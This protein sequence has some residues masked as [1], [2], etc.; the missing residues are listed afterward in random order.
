GPGGMDKG[1]PAFSAPFLPL[2]HPCPRPDRG[3]DA[4]KSHP[5]YAHRG[6]RR[7]APRLVSVRSPLR[8]SA[9]LSLR[10][11]PAPVPSA[12]SALLCWAAAGP[13]PCTAVSLHL[14]WLVFLSAVDSSPGCPAP[15]AVL[16]EAL[17]HQKCKYCA[18]CG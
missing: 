6:D 17:P 14:P 1:Q 5:A 2:L 12:D 3:K 15:A 4:G 18:I 8:K 16:R 9:G 7:R 13:G 11:S 10:S